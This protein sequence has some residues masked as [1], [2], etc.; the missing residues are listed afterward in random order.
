MARVIPYRDSWQRENEF[1]KVTVR[2]KLKVIFAPGETWTQKQAETEAIGAGYAFGSSAPTDDLAYLRT[3]RCDR[4][5]D[6]SQV[7]DVDLEYRTWD[8]SR[9]PINDERM[10]VSW[11]AE[12]ETEYF[13]TSNQPADG[14][15]G[16]HGFP[17]LVAKEVIR[18]RRVHTFV[19]E[20]NISSCVGKLNNAAF[21][22]PGGRPLAT[23]AGQLLFL[24]AE[25]RQL[26]TG[27]FELT[28]NFVR[29]L[30]M[31]YGPSGPVARNH[32]CI[33]PVRDKQTR[34][35]A[36]IRLVSRFPQV[37]FANLMRN[38]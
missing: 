15:D 20:S 16:E 36:G 9:R 34:K 7:F 31:A 10:D 30:G 19:Y 5:P 26:D 28:F 2:G 33:L 13:D 21:T 23:A 32:A 37:S 35:T 4:N 29:D 22:T 11:Q 18:I 6:G 25:S 12:T 24:G 14:A 17:S 3:I 38:E 8:E 1:G 27:K